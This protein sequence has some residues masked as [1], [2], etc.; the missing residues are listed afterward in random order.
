[1][2]GDIAA[3]QQNLA[4][5]KTHGFLSMGFR[6]PQETRGFLSMGLRKPCKTHGFLS[7]GLKKTKSIRMLMA[8]QH[9]SLMVILS[10][11][12]AIDMHKLLYFTMSHQPRELQKTSPKPLQKPPQIDT[13]KK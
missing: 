6:K 5:Q 12:Y 4:T 8:H 7:M 2:T 10:R 9:C 1:M 13:S 3:L 11:Q